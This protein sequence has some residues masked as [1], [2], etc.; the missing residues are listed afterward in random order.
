MQTSWG[1][2]KTPGIPNMESKGIAAGL[3]WLKNVGM[4]KHDSTKVYYPW[5]WQR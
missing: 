5:H 2:F 3:G 1:D 4:E